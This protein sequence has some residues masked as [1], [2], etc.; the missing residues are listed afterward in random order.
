[1]TAAVITV[2]VD[3]SVQELARLLAEHAISGAPVVD[4]S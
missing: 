2:G 4:E 1:M 3:T